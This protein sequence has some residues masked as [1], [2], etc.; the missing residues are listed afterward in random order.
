MET[1]IVGDV[2]LKAAEV[3]SWAGGVLGERPGIGRVV[4]VGDVCDDWGA[5]AGDLSRGVGEFASWVRARRAEGLAV[6]VL[7]G[8]HDFQYLLSEPG[9][10]TQMSMVPFVRETLFP[11]GLCAAV[12]VAGVLVTHAG[13]T[14]AWAEE[15]LGSPR[16]A[17]DA[18]ERLCAMLE[19]GPSRSLRALSSCGPGRGGRGVPGPLWAD[20]AE[21]LRDPLPGVPQAVGHTP[22]ATAHA[23]EAAGGEAIWFC[24]T[25]SFDSRRRALG[26]GT[27]LVVGEDGSAES[28]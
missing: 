9:P 7:F 26:D 12:S 1:L 21:L 15:H 16:R 25:F 5:T 23:E 17:R 3:L 19:E 8:N 11:L 27:M 6:D 2:H 10:G 24:D 28:A 20:R 22:V 13:V 14:R 18:A 4:F